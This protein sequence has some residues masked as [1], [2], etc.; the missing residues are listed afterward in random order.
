[1]KINIKPVS[2]T[3]GAPLPVLARYTLPMLTGMF[4]QQAYNL[5]DSWIAGNQIS[6]AALG[7]VGTCYPITVFY[8]AIASGLSMGTSIFCSQNF[9]AQ[10]FSQVKDGIRTALWCFLP[11]SILLM[12]LSLPCVSAILRWLAVPEDA[13]ELSGKYLAIYLSGIPFLF[14]YNISTGILNGLGDSKTPL[15]FLILSSLVNIVLDFLL[16]MAVPFGISGLA[17]AT[18]LSQAAAA[19]AT[20]FAVYRI[21]LRL[22]AQ[23][24][25]AKKSRFPGQHCVKFWALASPVSYSTFL[26]LPDSLSCRM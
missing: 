17:F 15:F 10:K 22:P 25:P 18:M 16:V 20:L 13:M 21:C 12:L 5:A 4:F 6:S 8:I 14:L 23:D 19:F 1:M 26:C 2:L 9:G 3:E 24:E 11:F 7:A